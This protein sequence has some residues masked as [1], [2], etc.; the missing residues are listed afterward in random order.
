MN[1]S[2]NG[3]AN[4]VRRRRRFSSIACLVTVGAIILGAAIVRPEFLQAQV[5]DMDAAR[6][7]EEFRWGVEAYHA[8]RFNDAI[9]AFNRVLALTPNDHIAR[10]WLGRAYL[11]S[12]FEDAAISEWEI[13]LAN[14]A[15]GAYLRSRLEILQYRRGIMPFRDEELLFSRSRVFRGGEQEGLDF[16]RPTG[17]ATEPNGDFFLVSL[18][19]QEVLR[20]NP[21]GRVRR[22]LRGGLQGLNRPF[23]AEWHEGE[24]YVT[25]FGGNRIAVLDEQGNRVR[26]IGERGLG[27][28]Q[29]LAPQYLAIGRNNLVYVTD[30]GGR[31]ISVFDTSGSFIFSFGREGFDFPGL[32]R[33]TG[34]AVKDDR[35]YVAEH[36]RAGIAL[37]VF[38]TSGNYRER[39]SLPLGD[40]DAPENSVT[41]V[42]VESLSWY[43]AEH[44]LISAGRR[45]L[46]FELRHQR[47]AAI[48][49]DAE[50]TRIAAAAVDA[51][52]RVLVSD[53][54]TSEL[55]VFEPEGTLYSGL[56]VHIERILVRG[57]PE[58][59]LLLA[60]QDRDG[61]PLVGLSRENFI[62][63]ERG[64]P[65]QD[66]RIE[67]TG[68]AV[69]D[70]DISVVMQP[71]PGEVYRGDAAQAIRD[72]VANVP[73]GERLYLY[74]GGREP[75]LVLQRPASVEQFV[76]RTTVSLAERADDSSA[77]NMPLDRAIRLAAVPLLDRGLRRNIIIVGDGTVADTAF[78]EYG[79]EETAAFLVNNDIRLHLVL[80]QSRTPAMELQFL[81]D[82]TS[83]EVQF[84]YEPE[85]VAP[86]IARFLQYPS[87]RYWLTYTSD[88]FPD[89]GRAYIPVSAETRLFVRSG[90]DELGF[91]PPPEP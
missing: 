37:V 56:D 85:G 81:V 26:H 60:V 48:I 42:T 61:R 89:F 32:R 3:A 50:R 66:F 78:D 25:E 54:D 57:F 8:A 80:L 86:L 40:D 21:N 12:G 31:K 18:G 64:I 83:G 63:S 10:E 15:G 58:I 65:Q 41:G 39:I 82:E 73:A 53:V 45:T 79:I 16:K 69:R 52:G 34:I 38:D 5:I 29:L 20:I 36:D 59:A 19:T 2:V 14:D 77:G 90:R 51:N 9:V 87:G 44:L 49:D 33:P 24:L 76:E 75:A 91:F 62:V 43:D 11:R 30:W 7:R 13:I 22:R 72:I 74:V 28:G 70:L 35:V 55:G 84:V 88:A 71:R 68:Q 67:S 17:I 23:D 4:T 27:D 46:L 1:G 47:V 6:A